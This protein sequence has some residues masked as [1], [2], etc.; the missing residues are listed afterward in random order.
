MSIRSLLCAAGATSLFLVAATAAHAASPGQV[1]YGSTAGS[2]GEPTI[3]VHTPVTADW[4]LIGV[5]D[6]DGDGTD[7]MVWFNVKTTQAHYWPMK[8][9]KRTGGVDIYMPV[10]TAWTLRGVGD[11]DGDGTDDLIWQSSSG[12]VH[13]WPMKAGKRNGGIDIHSPVGRE[14][15]LRGV[16]DVDGDG[17]DDLIWQHTNGQ[18]HYWPMNA[19]KRTGGIDIHAP[20]AADWEL[21]AV[22]DIDRDG[23][24]DLVWQLKTAGQVHYWKMS[25]GKRV[26]G[27]DMAKP[28]DADW[29]LRG[30]GDV[31]GDRIADLVWQV[32]PEAGANPNLAKLETA[33][34]GLASATRETV[35][36]SAYS[37]TGDYLT[38]SPGDHI[39]GM[40][41]LGP[42]WVTNLPGDASGDRDTGRVL[43][44]DQ[45]KDKYALR[46][47]DADGGFPTG[48]AILDRDNIL[49]VTHAKGTVHFFSFAGGIDNIA[50]LASW[51]VP[52]QS[53][54]RTIGAAFNSAQGKYY[55]LMNGKLYRGKYGAWEKVG[56]FYWDYDSS[57]E[58]SIALTYLGN[59]TFAAF[60]PYSNKDYDKFQ[61]TIFTVDA[62]G[63]PTVV[64]RDQEVTLKN[65]AEDGET[66]AAMGPNFRWSATVNFDGST[67]RMCTSPRRLDGIFISARFYCW[68]STVAN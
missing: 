15:F 47:F 9:G 43:F 60:L 23:T 45:K 3:N 37:S 24:E 22:A 57:D 11:V 4:R 66:G 48:M 34:K 6:V 36:V 50:E 18:V 58:E 13:Y 41:Q 62:A 28:V 21:R 2:G 16:G 44:Y 31:N 10:G 39:N 38:L 67:F 61:Y 8:A 12:Q 20:V 40:A 54:L 65:P 68:K 26:E 56:S 7:D 29:A 19:G 25:G 63:S 42:L 59:N 33:I 5:G 52:D 14:W 55:L 46:N 30:A 64:S 32:R 27:Y 51:T 35:G 1:S 53:D 17:T 49:A